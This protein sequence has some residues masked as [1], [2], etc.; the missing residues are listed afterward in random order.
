MEVFQSFETFVDDILDDI[1]CKGLI[2]ASFEYIREATRIHVFDE[3][4]EAVLEIITIVI[5]HNVTMIA[6]RH[7]S[8]FIPNGLLMSCDNCEWSLCLTDPPS[9]FLLL[10]LS[11]RDS[12]SLFIDKFQGKIALV[13]FSLH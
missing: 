5:L 12:A 7:Q 2:V 10:L 9:L 13:H 6:N 4:P 1:F 3:N 11:R 8:D